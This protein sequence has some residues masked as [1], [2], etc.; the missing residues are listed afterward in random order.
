VRF[1]RFDL[2]N[3]PSEPATWHFVS[4]DKKDIEAS[5]QHWTGETHCRVCAKAL[6]L[7][8]R[9]KFAEGGGGAI[10]FCTGL[11]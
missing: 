4:I 6:S 1:G 9:G 3:E 2:P 10:S 11:Q 8:T 5:L 7:S